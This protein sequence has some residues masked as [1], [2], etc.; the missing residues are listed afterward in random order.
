MEFCHFSLSDA[1]AFA[2]VQSAPSA[3][4]HFDFDRYFRPGARAKSHESRGYG[5]NQQIDAARGLRR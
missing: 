5:A 2:L 1:H 4:N 3:N